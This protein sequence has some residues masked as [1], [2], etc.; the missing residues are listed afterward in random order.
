VAIDVATGQIKGH[1]QYN[2]NES[3]DWDEVSPPLLIDYQRNGRTI[4]GL[5][6]VARDGYLWFLERSAGPIT[7]VEG[8]PYV[9]QNVFRSLDPKTGKP[10]VDPEHKP[11]TGKRAEFCPGSH[12]GKNWPPIAFNPQTRMIYIPANNGLCGALTGVPV[13]YEAGKG[14]AGT[15]FGGPGFAAPGADHVGGEVQAWNVDTGQR[16][17]RHNYEFSPNW[18]SMLTTAG[19]LVFTGGTN[20]RKIHAF[21]AATGK[22]LWESVT[23]SGIVAPPSTFT[24]DGKQYL[25]VHAGWGGDVRGMNGGLGRMFPGKVPE[26]PEGGGIWVYALP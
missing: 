4:K 1:F 20:D 11:G 8:K 24:V 21:D 17:W 9:V 26:P 18:G 3:W 5:V 25:A 2:P 10:D 16:V 14:F 12:G 13:T 23:N 22:L 15:Q 19:G 7:F 6:N